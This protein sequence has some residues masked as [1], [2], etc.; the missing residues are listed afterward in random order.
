MIGGSLRA[1]PFD[2]A[3]IVVAALLLAT[4]SVVAWDTSTLQDSSVYGVGPKAIPYAIATGLALLAVAN[5]V[6]ALTGRMPSR[7]TGDPQ[8]ILLIFGGLI[9]LMA[10]IALGGGFIPATAVLFAATS[11][12]FGR[13]APLT[14]LAIGAALGFLIFLMFDKVLTLALPEGPIERL[15]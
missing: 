5:L 13:R 4:A 1:R 12:A 2:P 8:A 11:T 7:E 15:L 6:M 14:D 9:A 10:L 3:G